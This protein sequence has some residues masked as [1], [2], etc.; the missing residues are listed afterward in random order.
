[1]NVSNFTYVDSQ[2]PFFDLLGKL[3]GTTI[4][5]G[6]VK[7]SNEPRAGEVSI[8][9]SNSKFSRIELSDKLRFFTT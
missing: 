5:A 6:E 9:I 1:M 8:R 3:G 4:P 7:D 2:M